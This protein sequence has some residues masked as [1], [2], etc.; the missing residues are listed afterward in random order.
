MVNFPPKGGGQ[1]IIYT[2][3]LYD[4]YHKPILHTVFVCNITRW[5]WSHTKSMKYEN[6]L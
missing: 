6:W 1:K 5:Y 4:Q 3:D 2:V